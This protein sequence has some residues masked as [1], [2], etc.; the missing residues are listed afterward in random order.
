MTHLFD[1]NVD[2]IRTIL[3]NKSGQDLQQALAAEL[4]ALGIAALA[5]DSTGRY[6]AANGHARELTGYSQEE[7]RA[8][9]VMDLTPPASVEDAQ[10]LWRAFIRSGAQHGTYELRRKH[11]HPAAVRYWAFANIAPGIH[12]S[13]MKSD[14]PGA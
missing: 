14:T 3:A 4:A 1:V 6:I 7:L 5:A 13:L 8:M 11:G 12:L 2:Y 9:S 10:A